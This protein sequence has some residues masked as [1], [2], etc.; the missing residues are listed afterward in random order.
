MLYF[1]IDNWSSPLPNWRGFALWPDVSSMS[2]NWMSSVNSCSDG[3]LFLSPL[4]WSMFDRGK[5]ICLSTAASVGEA[6]LDTKATR[7]C[8]DGIE[9]MKITGYR[10]VISIL[11]TKWTSSPV[12]LPSPGALFFSK[13]TWI[14]GIFMVLGFSTNFKSTCPTMQAFG[15]TNSMT[16]SSQ[17]ELPTQKQSFIF[18]G[19]H[20]IHW[21]EMR[22]EAKHTHVW[23]SDEGLIY[24]GYMWGPTR[25]TAGPMVIALYNNDICN[26]SKLLHLFC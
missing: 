21:T 20:V 15:R 9:Y 1:Q 7:L 3:W 26:V 25:L 5:E 23:W 24:W 16:C 12:T 4:T 10:P 2:M 18:S 19:K 13:V 11:Y 17:L 22:L 8:P 14:W 6:H